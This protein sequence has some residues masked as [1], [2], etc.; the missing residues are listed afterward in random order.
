[1]ITINK[2]WT[3]FL[4][5]DGVIN[6]RIPGR[7]VTNWAEF[8]FNKGAVDAI[9]QFTKLF[10]KIIV[11]TNQQGIDKG[12]MTATQLEDL[13][14]QMCAAILEKSG[15]LDRVYYSPKLATTNPI[16]RK[17]NTGMA[18][19][20]QKDFPSIDFQQSMMVGDSISDI[21]FGQRLGMK[22]VL[23]EGKKEEYEAS[24]S[25]QVDYRFDS[26]WDLAQSMF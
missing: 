12:I 13:H 21:E 24:R 3:L 18:F 19:Q 23:I 25:I 7:Y 16:C 10:G 20:A 8:Q 26:L 9:A 4:D 6:Q 22:T 15:R 11:V 17:P 1:M 5:R 2:D 14:Q